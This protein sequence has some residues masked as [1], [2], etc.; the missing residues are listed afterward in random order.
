MKGFKWIILLIIFMSITSGTNVFA[1]Q[2]L[3]SRIDSTLEGNTLY[4]KKGVY[5]EAIVLDKP[6]KVVGE[7][8]AS[9][10]S[11]SS[12]EPLITIT[13]QDVSLSGISIKSCQNDSSPAA[14]Y[15]SGNNH[16]LEKITID[17]PIVGIKFEETEKTNVRNISILGQGIENG[18]DLW[19]SHSNRFEKVQMGRVQDGFYME[20][21]H[22]NTFIDNTI[23]KS[24]YGFHIMF[25]DHITIK[26]NISTQNFTGA[27]VMGSKDS[28][29]QGNQLTE[30]NQN[31]NAQGLLLYDV[32]ESN[33]YENTISKNRVGLYMEDSNRNKISSNTVTANFVG[34]QLTKIKN[35]T[36]A[37]NSFISNV[38][39]LQANE[40]TNNILQNN[41]WDAALKLDTDGDGNS[42]LPY[43]ADP[44][45]LNLSKDF[46]P[47]Q[48]FFQHPGMIL[49]QKMLKT[50]EEQ[51]VVDQQ[52]LMQNTIEPEN[53][54]KSNQTLLWSISFI[55]IA[56]SLLFFYFGRRKT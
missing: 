9:F 23:R 55:M 15:V 26:N 35:N 7:K 18:I 39:E 46:P 27:M 20:N 17:S 10:L 30:N 53:K 22:L 47:Y 33:I 14:I 38:N 25:S 28:L 51:L 11:C 19:E 40:E 31:V 48:L 16:R 21:S 8:G 2:S 6:I 52:P 5:R 56:S 41:Y 49:L 3:Q 34:T 4:L 29:I 13:G 1:A 50:P 32:H 24:R 12:T 36:I 45:F 37:N 44:F 54:L 43:R 42:N